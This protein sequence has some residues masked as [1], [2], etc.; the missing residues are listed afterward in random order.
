M[1][2]RLRVNLFLTNTPKWVTVTEDLLICSGGSSFRPR[3]WSVEVREIVAALVALRSIALVVAEDGLVLLHVVVCDGAGLAGAHHLVQAARAILGLGK[4]GFIFADLGHD[5][6]HLLTREAHDQAYEPR[7]QAEADG[8]QVHPEGQLRR[9]EQ[10]S[11]DGVSNHSELDVALDEE[12]DPEPPVAEWAREN[13]KLGF[14]IVCLLD[15]RLDG[16]LGD[17]LLVELAAVD[18]VE[19]V[20]HDEAL[21]DPS[22]VKIGRA[23]V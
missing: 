5:A 21:E 16:S 8:S 14:E 12:D 13:V 19:Q 20:H 23:H 4:G 10:L 1:Q 11:S 2:D 3:S 18:H 6:Q 15:L 17:G 7:A 22:L 9:R